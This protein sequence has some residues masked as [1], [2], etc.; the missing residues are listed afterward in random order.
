MSSGRAHELV[1]GPTSI[2][3]A[4]AN[5][6]AFTTSGID[7]ELRYQMPLCSDK[8]TIESLATLLLT[9]T[10]QNRTVRHGQQPDRQEA[11]DHSD[12]HQPGACR[13]DAAFG[14]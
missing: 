7:F 6:R 9:S 1:N 8:L 12:E 13:S 14:L 3:V 2:L 4:N 11:A 5:L 10:Q